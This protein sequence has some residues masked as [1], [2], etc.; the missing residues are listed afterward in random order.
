MIGR[1][2]RRG[3][4]VVALIAA[5][6]WPSSA[7]AASVPELLAEGDRLRATPE[8]REDDLQRAVALYE[9]AGALEPN[10]AEIRAKLSDAAL[11]LGD[12]TTGDPLRWYDLG[13]HAAE[14]AV[15]L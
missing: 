10:S 15:A 14:R 7:V 9:Q 2:W 12:W 3:W 13:E 1:T 4:I 8:A 5:V 11:L 6:A